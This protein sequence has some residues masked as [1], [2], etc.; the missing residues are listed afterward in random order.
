MTSNKIL[1]W[2]GAAIFLAIGFW[3]TGLGLQEANLFGWRQGGFVL[4]GGVTLLL[5]LA[6]HHAMKGKP[7][8]L[9]GFVVLAL[10]NVVC[11]F[12]YLFP[13]YAGKLL[14]SEE[15]SELQDKASQLAARVAA[16]AKLTKLDAFKQLVESKR[17][18]LVAEVR[19]YGVG[20]QA[21]AQIGEL[22]SLFPGQKFPRYVAARTPEE[23]D[24]AAD[25]YLKF[26][27]G[28]LGSHLRENDFEALRTLKQAA[29]AFAG[30]PRRAQA[31]EQLK[32]P[33]ERVSPKHLTLLTEGTF[34]FNELCAGAN[35]M[36]GGRFQC[37]DDV[38]AGPMRLEA[39][40]T[41][42]GS[43]SHTASAV[44]RSLDKGALWVILAF[45]LLVDL[46]APYILY[47]IGREEPDAPPFLPG[48]GGRIAA[49]G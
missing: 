32:A 5:A 13:S 46:L 43:F 22:E 20:P 27:D 1:V 21:Q 44:G 9:A 26:T 10:F 29:G 28:L 36:H 24:R 7:A 34:L 40:N 17:D 48:R 31:I 18:A 25:S 14:V 49:I 47:R 4:S 8:A 2:M 16:D 41:S 30:D 45:C 42:L 15:L 39:R 37:L 35:T 3:H 19:L 6:F 33:L 11:N 12:N 38:A 23:W